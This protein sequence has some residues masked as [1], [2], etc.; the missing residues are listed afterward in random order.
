MPLAPPRLKCSSDT[1]F[2][3]DDADSLIHASCTSAVGLSVTLLSRPFT[4]EA[5][6]RSS[7]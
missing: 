5:S 2:I 6:L 4:A 1:A 3:P 7:S